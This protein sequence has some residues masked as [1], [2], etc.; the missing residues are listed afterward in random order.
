MTAWFK[1]LMLPLAIPT[2][3]LGDDGLR[4]VESETKTETETHSHT[5][6]MM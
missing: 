3:F 2:A 1:G 5:H 6:R 4:A